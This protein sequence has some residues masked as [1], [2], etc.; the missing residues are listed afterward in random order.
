VATATSDKVDFQKNDFTS[1]SSVTAC[2]HA[3]ILACARYTPPACR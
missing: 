2:R 3:R 1:T